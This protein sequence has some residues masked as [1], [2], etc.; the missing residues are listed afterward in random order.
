M[1]NSSLSDIDA[2]PIPIGA[3]VMLVRHGVLGSVEVRIFEENYQGLKIYYVVKTS[4]GYFKT[5][6]SGLGSVSDEP[7]DLPT[8]VSDYFAFSLGAIV[9]VVS[10]K[11]VMEMLVV[12]RCYTDGTK[13]VPMEDYCLSDGINTYTYQV[14]EILGYARKETG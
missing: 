4:I 12:S 9:E 8:D 13:G 6:D 3:V 1:K 14:G 7:M 5:L 2:F 11:G 10:A